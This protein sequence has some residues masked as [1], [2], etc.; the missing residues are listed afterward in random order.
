MV[1]LFYSSDLSLNALV[2]LIKYAR[3]HMLN[4]LVFPQAA[5]D[6]QLNNWLDV[7]GPFIFYVVVWGLVL[8]E[9]V[10]L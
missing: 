5:L 10:F 1:S 7:F 9:L 4:N 2:E 6:G 8:L 3:K